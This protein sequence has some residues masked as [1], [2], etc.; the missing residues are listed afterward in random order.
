MSRS[1]TPFSSKV[2]LSSSISKS[3]SDITLRDSSWLDR[4]HLKLLLRTLRARSSTPRDWSAD[5]L[6]SRQRA[7]NGF[8]E[9]V[10]LF[11]F[12][13]QSSDDPAQSFLCN[14]QTSLFYKN[15]EFELL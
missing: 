7:V 13:G 8:Q 15:F 2:D 4:K 6:Q 1:S 3:S 10:K 11:I 5:D 9:V 14:T 12:I